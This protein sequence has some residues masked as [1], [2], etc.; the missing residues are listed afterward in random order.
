MSDFGLEGKNTVVLGIAD[1]SSIA[2]GIARAFAEQ[3]AHVY[4]GYQQKFFSRVRLLI[5]D[6]PSIQAERCDV[7]KDD[8]VSA[9]FNRF[10]DRPIHA[11]VHAIAFGPPEIFTEYPSDVSPEAFEQTL[12]I[13]AYSLLKVARHAKPYLADWASLMT[14][15]FQAAERAVSMYGMMGVAKS[16]LES[17]VRYLAIELG[18][19]RIRVNAISPG[20]IETLSAT[21]E[22]LAL[23]ENPQALERQRS[24]LLRNMLGRVRQAMDRADVLAPAKEG[25]RSYQASLAQYSAIE[26]RISK[27]DVAGCALFLASDYSRKI[28]GQVFKVDCG[29]SSVMTL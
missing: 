28:T 21:G 12:D 14:I 27:E 19:R 16:A 22:V 24:Q 13:S 6:F 9:F 10:H 7:V 25:W 11:M 5:R 15:S 26:E 8:E 4:A 29:L 23:I 18:P 2:W 3:G 20:V 17:I 1:E